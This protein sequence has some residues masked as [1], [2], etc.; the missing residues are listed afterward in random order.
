MSE[1]KKVAV[2]SFFG[3]FSIILGFILIY[4]NW[5]QISNNFH[6]ITYLM[7]FF[8]LF[9]LLI[10]VVSFM[11]AIFVASEGS[12]SLDPL[13]DFINLIK[14]MD[15]ILMG[16]GI[17]FSMLGAILVIICIVNV[18]KFNENRAFFSTFFWFIFILTIFSC[19][20]CIMGFQELINKRNFVNFGEIIE[21]ILFYIVGNIPFGYTVDLI[22]IY[23]MLVAPNVPQIYMG[24][25]FLANIAILLFV[26]SIYLGKESATYRPTYKTTLSKL[27]E[28]PVFSGFKPYFGEKPMIFPE[29]ALIPNTYK[30]RQSIMIFRCPYCQSIT[31][32]NEALVI[33]PKCQ[34]ILKLP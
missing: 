31:L 33:C 9:D 26:I 1:N 13:T 7:Y 6:F 15:P 17:I 29:K 10:A 4:V 3:F 11:I 2:F 18:S 24:L 22:G 27:P 30:P 28:A 34:K 21:F 23:I 14:G 16:V 32:T 5:I 8:N 25:T 20:L 12:I 19:V